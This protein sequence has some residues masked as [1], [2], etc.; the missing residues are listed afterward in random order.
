MLGVFHNHRS[1]SFGR[2]LSRATRHSTFLAIV[3][4][5]SFVAAASLAAQE[6]HRFNFGAGAGF[7]K[8]VQSAANG[9]NGG[10]NFDV[11]GGLNAGA[12]ADIDLDFNYNHFG[13]NSSSLALFGEPGGS[14]GVWSLAL[15][16]A[17]HVRPRNSVANAYATAGF[18]IFH[19]NLSLTRPTVLTG[20]VCDPF[21][22][23]FPVSYGANQVV[24][25][26]T[27]V[28][29]GFNIG[30]GLE[31]RIGKRSARLFAESRY[32]RM[33]TNH[34]D[35]FSYVPVTFGFRW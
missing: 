24:A 27:S 17:W 19:R 33:F 7:S 21:W 28:K 18:G 29:P 15:Q 4:V 9:L 8:P 6:Q 2:M 10:W 12:H 13:L 35:D 3:S 14:V 34:G 16:P 20:I 22:G 11:Q 25:S 26:F 1:L 5:A 31:F 32:E 23:C 30:G